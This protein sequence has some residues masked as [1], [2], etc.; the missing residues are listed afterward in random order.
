[1]RTLDTLHFFSTHQDKLLQMEL[2]YIIHN[3]RKWEKWTCYIMENM[4]AIILMSK[5]FVFTHV[6]SNTRKKIELTFSI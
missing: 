6:G 1:M 4:L 3:Y 2:Q 5:S